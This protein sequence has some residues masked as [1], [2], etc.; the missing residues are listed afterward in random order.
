[1]GSA[2][3]PTSEADCPCPWRHGLPAGGNGHHHP[4]ALCAS[5]SGCGAPV[6]SFGNSLISYVVSSRNEVSQACEAHPQVICSI[7]QQ[8]LRMKK[9]TY[10][11]GLKK[12]ILFHTCSMYTRFDKAYSQLHPNVMCS[13]DPN[14]K[15]KYTQH[16]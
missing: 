14:V 11:I 8:T 1:M 10:Y 6:W 16:F 5:A 9:S 4:A 2:P 3:P 7:Q 12:T 13:P 15:F